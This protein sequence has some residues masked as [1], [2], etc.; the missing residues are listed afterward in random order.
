MR[1]CPSVAWS[2]R[3]S[4]W[5]AFFKF[6]EI[7]YFP[8]SIG[9][10]EQEWL[11]MSMC[12]YTTTWVTTMTSTT[13]TTTA[14]KQRRKGDAS[15]Y[16]R[17][18]FLR[19]WFQTLNLYKSSKIE[20]RNRYLLSKRNAS[21]PAAA[22]IAAD[23]PLSFAQDRTWFSHHHLWMLLGLILLWASFICKR[24]ESMAIKWGRV[25]LGWTRKMSFHKI[26]RLLDKHDRVWR[27][28]QWLNSIN[29]IVEFRHW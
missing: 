25:K 23:G 7:W 28:K 8:I 10:I 22:N 15:L 24:K 18:C 9:R 3:P 16:A 13:T 27:T 29:A 2:V 26:A 19:K 1:V 12:I 21:A 6:A 4:V 5:D 14:T 17:T 20:S 11:I